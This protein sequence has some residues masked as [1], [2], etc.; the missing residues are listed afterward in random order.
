MLG[1][2][3]IETGVFATCDVLRTDCI[4]IAL[5]KLFTIYYLVFRGL[6]LRSWAQ[7]RGTHVTWKTAMKFMALSNK[8]CRDHLKLLGE[9]K[10]LRQKEE[11]LWSWVRSHFAPNAED[12]FNLSTLVEHS[13]DSTREIGLTHKQ[14]WS[15]S[16]DTVEEIMTSITK[17]DNT[18]TLLKD[19]YTLQRK[20]TEEGVPQTMQLCPQYVQL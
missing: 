12:L 6:A 2:A 9:E 19:N 1:Q 13:D 17:A 16:D 15:S 10:P 20:S 5:P 11:R 3:E 18:L 7:E 8:Y 4:R 14:S